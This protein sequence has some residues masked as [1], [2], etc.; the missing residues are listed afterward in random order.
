MR[1]QLAGV[2]SDKQPGMAHCGEPG[3]TLARRLWR[4][5][6]WWNGAIGLHGLRY[7]APQCFEQALRKSFIRAEH[8]GAAARPVQHR[9]PLGLLMLSRGQLTNRQLRSALD[10][11]RESGRYRLGEWLEKLGFAT[12]QQVTAALGAQ[13]SCPVVATRIRPDPACIPLLPYRLLEHYRMLPLQFVPRTRTLYLAFSHGINYRVLHAIEQI[14]ECRANPCLVAPSAW[15]EAMQQITRDRGLGDFLFEG[16]RDVPE[17]A[18]ITCSYVLK[19]GADD[20]RVAG[21]EGHIWA[22]LAAGREFIHL[23]FRCCLADE[24]LSSAESGPM[25][26]RVVG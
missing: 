3:C 17:M 11:Q 7:C 14:L 2:G 23:L 21:V 1:L 4:R 22:R 25:R 12:E 18:R 19:L 6:C 26:L 10:A 13:W 16:W 5:V 9:I 24:S 8:A 20:V 15:D